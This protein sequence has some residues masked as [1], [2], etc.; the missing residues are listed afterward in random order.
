MIEVVEF[1]FHAIVM[2]FRVLFRLIFNPVTEF[3][4]NLWDVC[5]LFKSRKD[6]EDKKR[7]D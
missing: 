5:D 3:F 1:I 7:T 2:F 4:F 6:K